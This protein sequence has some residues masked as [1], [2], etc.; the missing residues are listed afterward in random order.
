MKSHSW[1]REKEIV[2]FLGP[3]GVG[4]TTTLRIALGMAK[5][6]NGTVEI[7]GRDISVAGNDVRKNLS[8]L[9]DVPGYPEWMTAQEFLRFCAEL[10]GLPESVARPRIASLLQ[11]A[12][13][14]GVTQKIGGYSRGMKQR[15]G[16]AQALINAP[17]LLLLDEPTSALDPLGRKEVL[18]MVEALRGKATV[19]FSTHLLDDVERVCDRAV[20]L[21]G[22]RVRASGTIEE[23]RSRYGMSRKT[24][25]CVEGNQAALR[26]SLIAQPW[27]HGV[28]ADPEGDLLVNAEPEAINRHIVQILSETDCAL[29]SYGR[30]VSTLEEA[31]SQI[32]SQE[33]AR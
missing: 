14:A 9:P 10:F 21:A 19:L 2:G 32:V 20:V 6:T 13:L 25:L 23:L 31:F 15:L 18:E 1:F 4:K 8:Y 24:R 28:E 5:A 11:L 26:S 30:A 7:L 33:V 3:N 27:C 12:G 22:G 16:I 29:I 17:Q